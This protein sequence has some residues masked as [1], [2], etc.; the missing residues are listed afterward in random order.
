MPTPHSD[1]C[2]FLQ[3]PA[4]CDAAALIPNATGLGDCT[5]DLPHGTSCTNIPLEGN[6]CTG[7]F[8]LNA[9]CFIFVACT[10]AVLESTPTAHRNNERLLSCSD[11]VV[12]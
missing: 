7:M 3:I 1:S 4:N 8:I 12:V 9:A 5:D 10:S 2:D 6:A 11:S